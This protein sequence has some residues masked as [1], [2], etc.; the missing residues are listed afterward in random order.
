MGVFPRGSRQM[1]EIAG[2][3]SKID[4]RVLAITKLLGL[5]AISEG[6]RSF[7]QV[8]RRMSGR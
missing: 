7:A 8:G 3:P 4:K 2:E 5:F 1:A 6:D